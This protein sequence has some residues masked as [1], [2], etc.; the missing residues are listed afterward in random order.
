MGEVG[1]ALT[2]ASTLALVVL[3]LSGL[4]LRWPRKMLDWRAWLT[5]NTAL[6]GRPFLWR[7]HAVTGTWVLLL[8]LLACLTGLFWSY[9]WY[10]NGL[11]AFT[12]ASP[13]NR[14]GILLETP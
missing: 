14:E 6:K 12:G 7:L 4:Y 3:C 1:K 2:G 11:Y 13:P 5:F 8:Y 9:E 10:R